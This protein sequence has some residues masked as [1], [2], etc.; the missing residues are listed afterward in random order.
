MGSRFQR[1][2]LA[3]ASMLILSFGVLWLAGSLLIAPVN[4][5]VGQLPAELRGSPV[6]FA[7]PSGTTLK[8]WLIPGK[9]GRGAVALMH[10]VRANRASMLGRAKFLSSLGYTLLLFDFQAHG[11]SLGQHI[12]F[13][14]LESRDAQ[15]AIMFLRQQAPGEK[16]GLIG[17]SMGGA[18]ALLAEP[19]LEVDAIVLEMV[20][21]SMGQAVANRLIM[22]LGE[23]SGRLSALLTWQFQP[24]LGVEVDALA[25]I[26]K[27]A[28]LEVPKL[29]V[30]GE[31][32]QHT[33]LEE[34]RWMFSLARPPKELWVVEGANHTD[35]HAFA[36][37]KY[38]RR[39]ASF[40]ERFLSR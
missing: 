3:V 27:V 39:V 37:A 35:L 16:V 38:E 36:P 13:G 2:F 26:R 21:S 40:L 32:D 31:L 15:A 19:P 34:S 14:H 30:V 10:G 24:R 29:F 20:Y 4:Q 18:A 9:P 28:E 8:G 12:T 5:P 1:C 17:V 25:P 6:E 7:N 23:W 22:R 33:T 11:E